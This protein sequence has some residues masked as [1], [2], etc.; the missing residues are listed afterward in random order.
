MNRHKI[1]NMFYNERLSSWLPYLTYDAGRDLYVNADGTIGFM[2]E[3]PP[4]VFAGS[5]M[6]N[7]FTSILEQEW[8]EKALLQFIIYADPNIDNLLNSYLQIR[9]DILDLGQPR[10][11]FLYQWAEWQA[12]Y[13]RAHRKQGISHEVPVPFRNFRT[14]ITVKCPA[15]TADISGNASH[16]VSRLN[17]LRDNIVGMLRSNYVRAARVTPENLNRILWQ[18]WNPAHAY[19][20]PEL[21]AWNLYSYLRDQVVAPDT[22]I[23]SGIKG[24]HVDRHRVAVKIPQTYPPY[25]DALNINQLLG[26]VLHGADQQQICCPFLITLN[27]DPTPAA[28]NINA[29]AEITAMQSAALRALAPK[30]ARKN[31]E[32]TWATSLQENGVKFMRGYLTLLLYSNAPVN[33]DAVFSENAAPRSGLESHES[34]TEAWWETLRFR[35]QDELFAPLPYMLAAMPFG[36][37][38]DSLQNM[39]RFQTC[40]SSTFAVMAPIQ[41]D[42]RGTS[43]DAMLFLTRRGQVCSLNFFD[44]DTNYNFAVAA[45][46]GSG[47][48]FLV[49]KIL[50]EHAGQGGIVYVIDIGRSY[51]KQCELQ[52]GQYIEF[53]AH[54]KISVN[55]FAELDARGFQE[56]L[57]E[58]GA[59]EDDISGQK[60]QKATLLTLFTQLLAVMANPTEPIS[61]LE[62]SILANAIQVAYSRLQKGRIMKVDNFVAVLD[63]RQREYD[64]SGKQ[65]HIFGHLAERLRPYCEKGAYGKWLSGPMNIDF[66]KPFVVLELEELNN[67]KELREVVLLLIISYIERKF[68]LGNRKIPKIV[69]FDEAW[70]LFRNPNTAAFIETAYRRM[71]KYSGSIGTIVQSFL[72]FETSGNPS[73]G[74]AILSN[75]EW[76]LALQPKIEDLRKCVD[77]HMLSLT[78]AEFRVAETIHTV[79]G[80]Y[81]E[82]MLMSSRSSAVFRFI[83]S[84]VEL[85]AFTTDPVQVQVYE[86]IRAVLLKEASGDEVDPLEA[87]GLAGY[88]Y[89]LME[90]GLPPDAAQAEALRDRVKAHEYARTKFSAI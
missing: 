75:S 53:K 12:G 6:V 76:K 5:N 70:D 68:Y 18:L 52:L 31:E 34:V 89:Y 55:V 3:F 86:E 41:A 85:L 15:G 77:K 21:P 2:L 59:L 37:Y 9:Q 65:D 60:E 27:I 74:Q 78:E 66:Q 24:V 54:I 39:S 58:S 72:D 47:K 44:S 36:L 14:F 50:Q 82:V 87:L 64:K 81:S 56:D 73:V 17:I 84:P 40:P 30:V 38:H 46:S 10:D 28:K 45:P 8:P 1:K 49:N 57:E 19:L 26:D 69:L 43:S 71:R 88:A 79:K 62:K 61:D 13:L 16:V 63:E 48:S 51:K 11:R 7:G 32:F 20:P 80:S 23:E 42:W 4:V 90:Q 25:I 22:E 29:K 35:L 33:A 83:P 67:Y